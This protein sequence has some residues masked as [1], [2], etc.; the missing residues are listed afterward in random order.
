MVV[1]MKIALTRLLTVLIPIA[2]AGS[3]VVQAAPSPGQ[4]APTPTADR[5]LLDRYCVAC[6]SDALRTAGLT[7]QGLDVTDVGQAPAVWEKVLGKLR[8]GG[9]PPPGRPRPTEDEAAPLLSWLETSLD[10]FALD[11]PN[12]GRPAVHRLNRTEYGNAVRDLLDLEV[13]VAVLL[14]PDDSGGGFD[15]IAD[16]LTISP[17]LLERYMSAAR[18]VSRLAIGDPAVRAHLYRV[19]RTLVQDGRTDEDLPIGTRG[20]VAIRHY[21]PVDGEYLIKLRLKRNRI[22]EIRG[23]LHTYRIDVLIDGKRVKSFPVG[24]DEPEEG[25]E[26]L[27]ETYTALANY[28]T[29]ADDEMEFQVPVTAGPHAVGVTFPSQSTEIE[30]PLEKTVQPLSWDYYHGKLGLAGIGTVEIRGPYNV[31]GTS[32]TPSR[33]RIFMCR[34]SPG[35]PESRERS[36]AEQIISTLAR[37]A[38]RR[39]LTEADLQTLFEF[40]ETGRTNGGF[41]AGVKLALQR[42][43]VSP[44]FLFRVEQDPTDIPPGAPYRLTDLEFA[45]RLSFFLWSSIPDDQLLD[46]AAR[47]E[48]TSPDVLAR[49]V[50]RMLV[51]P[52]SSALVSNFAAQWLGTRNLPFAVPNE[53]LFPEFDENLRRAFQRETE[54]FV[55]SI[56]REDRSVSDLLTAN[57]TYVN[58]R[59]ARHYG[60]PNVQGNWFRRVSLGPDQV[61]RGG[62]LGHGSVLTVT[63]LATRTSPVNRGKWILENILGT[64]PPPPPDDVPALEE[65][66]TE[67]QAFSMREAM[68]V[69]RKNP[70]CSACHAKM[71]P[72]GLALE[73]FNAIGAWRIKAE[74]DEVIDSSGALPGGATFTGPI[75]L[76]RVLLSKPE[77]F[78]ETVVEKLLMYATGRGLEYYDRAAMRSIAREAAADGYRL[79]SL[80]LGVVKSAPFQMRR[81]A[82]G[83]AES[84]VASQR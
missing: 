22:D 79:S 39:P 62:I 69:H 20:G 45:S 15:N 74:D 67:G 10:R 5:A 80:V 9:M 21:F 82:E 37:R 64:P 75:D 2:V 72:L 52:R 29:H 13:D 60:I 36:C 27:E 24:G 4:E 43:L 44:Y 38:F 33:S 51:D 53:D 71:D 77:Q 46:L 28:L 48:L 25:K 61:A 11:N 6:H 58:E 56:L 26:G 16:V 3:A 42:I 81:S 76:R 30:G 49:Q 78:A 31:T 57:H 14:P 68:A 84:T 8:T 63:S 40:Y 19:P 41:E 50:R 66:D 59:L 47:G 34:P 18:K 55:Q 1:V 65:E 73:N 54:L 7:L 83:Q 17:L 12:P 70:V 32:T 23:L 35:D